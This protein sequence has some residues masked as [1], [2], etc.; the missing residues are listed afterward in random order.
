MNDFIFP[1]TLIIFYIFQLINPKR[2]FLSDLL[3][4]KKYEIT[5]NNLE[6]VI[7]DKKINI[8]NQ[9]IHITGNLLT[10]VIFTKEAQLILTRS[11]LFL[12]NLNFI[13]DNIFKMETAIYLKENSTLDI[14]VKKLL[15]KIFN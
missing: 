8:T 1:K 2:L 14:E 9:E 12:K 6:E 4:K 10:N 15:K 3:N 7:I 11:K 5:I 13:N